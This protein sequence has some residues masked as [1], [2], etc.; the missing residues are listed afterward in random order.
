[1]RDEDT[2]FDLLEEVRQ[3]KPASRRVSKGILPPYSRKTVSAIPW[4]GYA[5]SLDL[6]L[7]PELGSWELLYATYKREE[8]P[9]PVSPKH[10]RDF[11]HVKLWLEV[12]LHGEFYV[13]GLFLRKGGKKV[14]RYLHQELCDVPD[15]CPLDIEVHHKTRMT[16]DNRRGNLEI[17]VKRLNNLLRGDVGTGTSRYV[18][19]SYHRGAKSKKNTWGARKK[20]YRAECNFGRKRYFIGYYEHEEEAALAYD[21]KVLELLK[22]QKGFVGGILPLEQVNRLINFKQSIEELVR[23]FGTSLRRAK[24]RGADKVSSRGT[25]QR[26][27]L[28]EDIPF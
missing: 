27:E 2:S 14:R 11:A 21:T 13:R 19:V 17:V 15:G 4:G 23:F 26:K 10:R 18:G 20:P 16:L 6:V 7:D 1:M 12:S 28:E 22:A 5:D 3:Q 25:K 24:T 9:V 8:Y